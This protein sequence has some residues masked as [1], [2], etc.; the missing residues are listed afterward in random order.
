MSV[1][2]ILFLVLVVW[3]TVAV[4]WVIHNARHVHREERW[5]DY[6]FAAPLFSIFWVTDTYFA[7]RRRWR[8]K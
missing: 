2:W 6:I 4:V 7:L 1:W 3:M 8:R 5:Y